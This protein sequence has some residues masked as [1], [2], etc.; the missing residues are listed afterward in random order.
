MEEEWRQRRRVEKRGRMKTE[1]KNGDREEEWRQI[2]RMETERNN[3]DK[4]EEW[5]QR[6]RVETERKN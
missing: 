3:G 2:G 4:E 6:G 5:R 1:R